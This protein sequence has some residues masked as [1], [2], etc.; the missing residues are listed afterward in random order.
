MGKK[1]ANNVY[2]L[3]P[4]ERFLLSLIT[5]HKSV[6]CEKVIVSFLA[7]Y[8]FRSRCNSTSF[9]SIEAKNWLRIFH[10]K[11]NMHTAAGLIDNNGNGQTIIN[12]IQ[13]QQEQ[14]MR[15]HTWTPKLNYFPSTPDIIHYAILSLTSPSVCPT[16]L[17]LYYLHIRD[18]LHKPYTLHNSDDWLRDKFRYADKSV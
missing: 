13:Q 2:L 1:K 8:I 6:G 4:A 3:L 18:G 12:V 10:L 11:S 17:K 14:K 5:E 9:S 15:S 16:R 7:V